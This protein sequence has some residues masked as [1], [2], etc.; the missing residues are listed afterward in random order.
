MKLTLPALMFLSALL[1]SGCSLVLPNQNKFV[2]FTGIALSEQGTPIPGA[3]VHISFQ[4]TPTQVMVGAGLPVI[5]MLVPAGKTRTDAHGR[6]AC[7]VQSYA[8]YQ[9]IARHDETGAYLSTIVKRSEA[10]KGA[11]YILRNAESLKP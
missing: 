6:F 7:E 5:A 8:H 11:R 3:D 1:T 10:S 9:L 4:P 2:Q